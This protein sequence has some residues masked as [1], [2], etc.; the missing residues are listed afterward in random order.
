M[1]EN[2]EFD[3]VVIGGN[4]YVPFFRN[5]GTAYVVFGLPSRR[6]ILKPWI[7]ARQTT[8]PRSRL[9]EVGPKSRTRR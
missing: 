2:A 9:A 7:V 4:D 3:L 5:D 8:C 1:G 6:Q